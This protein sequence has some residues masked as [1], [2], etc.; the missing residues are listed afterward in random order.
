[1]A[2]THSLIQTQKNPADENEFT[3]GILAECF[4]Y[5]EFFALSF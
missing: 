2:L 5:Y 4:V 1:M 3:N